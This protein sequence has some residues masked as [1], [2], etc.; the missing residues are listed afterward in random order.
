MLK[1]K[2]LDLTD[3]VSVAHTQAD[4][5]FKKTNKQLLEAIFSRQTDKT[6]LRRLRQLF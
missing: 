1:G 2:I 3:F 4:M 5:T 6:R